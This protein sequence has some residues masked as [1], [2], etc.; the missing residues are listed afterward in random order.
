MS[1]SF[2][3]LGA[4]Q[5]MRDLLAILETVETSC[6]NVTGTTA[7]GMPRLQ[8]AVNQLLNLPVEAASG[9][10]SIKEASERSYGPHDQALEVVKELDLKYLQ[11]VDVRQ[12][13]ARRVEVS[14]E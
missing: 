11:V 5:F 9:K 12:V 2:T 13:L 1:Q 4:A 8:E 10:I 14:S 7:L 3:P 6:R